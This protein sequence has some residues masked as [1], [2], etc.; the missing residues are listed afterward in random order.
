M[1]LNEFRFVVDID[2]VRAGAFTECTLPTIQWD[3]EKVIEGGQNTYIHQLPKGLK[4]STITLKRGLG[5]GGEIYNWYQ[6]SLTGTFLRKSVTIHLMDSLRKVMCSWTAAQAFPVKWTGP[7]LQAD[8]RAIA[9]ETLE[10]ACGLITVTYL[11]EI[12]TAT[13]WTKQSNS[14]TLNPS[15]TPTAP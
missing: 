3:I 2:S 10:I 13:W 6:S 15:T 14:T 12:T 7:R 9:I 8:S 1:L 4:E 11:S 5:L